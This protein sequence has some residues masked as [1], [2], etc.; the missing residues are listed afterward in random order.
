MDFKDINLIQFN[1]QNIL[2][3]CGII[4]HTADFFGSAQKFEVSKEW[5]LKVNQ[6]FKAQ[7]KEEEELGIP[8]TPY[9]KDLDRMDILA[10]SEIGFIKFIVR[11]LWINLN[12]FLQDD[13]KQCVNNLEDNI[14]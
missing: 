12:S 2:L 8:Q 3:L 9:L 4:T 13:L 5:S 7:Y 10:K 11:P 6:E 14:K 1:E